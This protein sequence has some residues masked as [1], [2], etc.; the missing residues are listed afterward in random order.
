MDSI[1]NGPYLVV[2]KKQS[3]III[4]IENKLIEVYENSI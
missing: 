1:F 2:E 4:K 3:K